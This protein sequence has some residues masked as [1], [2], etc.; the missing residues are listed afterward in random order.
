MFTSVNCLHYSRISLMRILSPT[1]VSY[2][3]LRHQLISSKPVAKHSPVYLNMASHNHS[4]ACCRIPPIQSQGYKEKGKY[5]TIGG[6][7]TCKLSYTGH[8]IRLTKNPIDVTGPPT[9]S[10]ALLFIFDIFGFYPQS[11][12]GADILSTSDSHAQYQVFM[13]DFFE[14]SPADYSW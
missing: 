1:K 5:E 13:P 9:A 6:L 14:G 2:T 10:K 7:K 11:L 4:A 8:C 12:Q 3:L